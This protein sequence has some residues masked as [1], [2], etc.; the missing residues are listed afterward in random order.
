MSNNFNE[1]MKFEPPK[2]KSKSVK[3]IL[4]SSIASLEE[5]GYDPVN[6]IIGYMLSGDPSYI[7]SYNDARALICNVER[8]E[9]LEELLTFYLNNKE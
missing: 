1:T 4:F 7:T 2:D 8:D 5:K 9:L 3:E 6:Q